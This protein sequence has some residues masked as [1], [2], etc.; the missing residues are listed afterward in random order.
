[1][2]QNG[3]KWIKMEQNGSKWI[4]LDQN[5]SNL[6]KLDL[7]LPVQATVGGRGGHGQQPWAWAGKAA[8]A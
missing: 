2:N 6:D 7:S 8:L 4:Y 1:M 5:G 3:S